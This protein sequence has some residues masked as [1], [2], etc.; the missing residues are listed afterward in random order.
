[1]QQV[2][3]GLDDGDERAAGGSAGAGAGD[4]EAAALVEGVLGLDDVLGGGVGGAGKTSEGLGLAGVEVG[5]APPEKKL[6][7]GGIDI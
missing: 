4:E 1:M 6:K 5:Q 7:N 2:Q 3:R